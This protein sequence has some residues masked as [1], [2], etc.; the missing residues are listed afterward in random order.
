MIF[1]KMSFKSKFVNWLSGGIFACYLWQCVPI[2]WKTF[3]EYPASIIYSGG[4]ESSPIL[5]RFA[6]GIYAIII[7][8]VIVSVDKL[9]SPVW[10][11]LISI[12]EQFDKKWKIKEVR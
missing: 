6:A 10:N 5:F 12:A 8:L 4:G 2:L 9:L 1:A 3:F 11:S 7:I